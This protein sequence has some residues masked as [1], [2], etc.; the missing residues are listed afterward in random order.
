MTKFEDYFHTN[1]S[2]NGKPEKYV[3]IS[4]LIDGI[5]LFCTIVNKNTKALQCQKYVFKNGEPANKRN[6]IGVTTEG[7]HDGIFALSSNWSQISDEDKHLFMTCANM[8]GKAFRQ[9][10]FATPTPLDAT[11]QQE[12]RDHINMLRGNVFNLLNGQAV[13]NPTPTM[14]QVAP[15]PQATAPQI[16]PKWV[17]LKFS[18]IPVEDLNEI[19]KKINTDGNP[20]AGIE[21]NGKRYRC[22]LNDKGTVE[23]R[24]LDATAQVAP[25][26]TPEPMPQVVTR[27]V[28]PQRRKTRKAQMRDNANLTEFVN[29]CYYRILKELGNGF[30]SIAND[31]G[32][33]RTVRTNRLNIVEVYDEAPVNA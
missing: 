10:C 5:G 19:I 31:N 6:Y 20:V 9:F 11:T 16:E 30:I 25:Q 13:T 12:T 8:L 1:Y 24:T 15:Q 28:A 26:A 21:H 17:T 7:F 18:T 3:K 32:E 4:V 2:S 14:P 33:E 27:P 22:V 23:L 29:G